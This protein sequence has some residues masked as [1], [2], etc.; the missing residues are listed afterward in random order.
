MSSQTDQ[1]TVS[2]PKCQHKFSIDEALAHQ[3]EEQAV[4]SLELKHKNELEEVKKLAEESAG[5][6]AEEQFVTQV[7]TLQKENDEEKERNKKLALQMSELLDAMKALRRKDEEREIEMKKKMIDEEEK[8]RQEV[9]KKADEENQLKNLEKDKKLNDALKQLEELQNKMQQGSQQT[10][11]EVLEL[12]LE[13]ILKKEFTQDV[14]EEV[15]KGERGA[16]IVHRVVDKLGRNS[17]TILWESKNAQW[18]NGWIAKLKEDQRAKKA[19]LAVLVTL[20]KPEGL[21]TFT[22]KEGVWLTTWEFVIPLALALRFNLVSI[23]HE[24][25]SSEGK[26]EKK[27]ILYQYLTGTEFKQ[28]VEAIVEAFGNLQGILEKEKRW[29]NSKWAQQE[30]EMRKVLDHTHGMHGDLQ[31]IIGASLPRLSGLELDTDG[32]MVEMEILEDITEE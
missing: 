5:K 1:I 16:D 2:C 15:K 28:R 25:S 20:H 6:K 19:D 29:F 21:D 3:M 8:I 4:A 27:E 14:I 30:K 9:R 12:E 11:G 32:T 18:Q 22:Y 13:R 10:Q 31:A 24:K 7:S 23:N 26:N 17:G